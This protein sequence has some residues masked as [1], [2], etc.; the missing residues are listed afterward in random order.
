MLLVWK[1]CG[2]AFLLQSC[3]KICVLQSKPSSQYFLCLLSKGAL[4]TERVVIFL[5]ST[6]FYT[7]MV[8]STHWMRCPRKSRMSTWLCSLPSNAQITLFHSHKMLTAYALVGN[9][10]EYSLVSFCHTYKMEHSSA[11]S[12]I[13]DTVKHRKVFRKSK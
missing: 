12:F 9:E 8:G 11:R 4:S 6:G 3:H 7:K 2:K 1:E 10:A 13:E 5:K